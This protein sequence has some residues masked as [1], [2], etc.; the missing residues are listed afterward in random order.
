MDERRALHQ[1]APTAVKAVDTSGAGDAFIGCFA[2]ALVQSAFCGGYFLIAISASLVIRS[3]SYK[4]AILMGLALYIAGCVLFYPASHMAAYTMF[5]A[6]IFAIVI[7][8]SFL[9]TAAIPTT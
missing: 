8:L 6:A 5:L 3:A 1:V 7:G 2:Q 4:L 9:E